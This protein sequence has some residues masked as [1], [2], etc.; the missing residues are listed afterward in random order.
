MCGGGGPEQPRNVTSQ[1]AGAEGGGHRDAA[2]GGGTA[3][4]GRRA[5]TIRSDEKHEARAKG[6]VSS[7]R[8][9]HTACSQQ[10]G[11][12]HPGGQDAQ[13]LFA[14]AHPLPTVRR[15][16]KIQVQGQAQGT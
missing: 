4:A 3:K 2:D 12:E 6:Q 10:P 8:R 13:Q 15:D 11:T 7:E 5:G 16:T 9:F 1:D 14:G